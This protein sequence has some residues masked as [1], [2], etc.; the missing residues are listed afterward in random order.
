MSPCRGPIR[1][2]TLSPFNT[3]RDRRELRDWKAIGTS[4]P[5]FFCRLFDRVGHLLRTSA[6]GSAPGRARGRIRR[7]Q[8]ASQPRMSRAAPFCH[9]VRRGIQRGTCRL[10]LRYSSPKRSRRLRH[11]EPRGAVSMML[12]TSVTAKPRGRATSAFA[13]PRINDRPPSPS[14]RVHHAARS[15]LD[16]SFHRYGAYRGGVAAL[17]IETTKRH[18]GAEAHEGAADDG[19]GDATLGA[20]AGHL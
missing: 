4:F 14:Q 9:G 3:F 13:R 12:T 10:S 1:W 8:A 6:A 16:P 11:S 5:Q 20:L 18:Q 7:V 17:H 19:T 2:T 15:Q